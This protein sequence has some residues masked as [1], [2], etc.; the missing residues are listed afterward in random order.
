MKKTILTVLLVLFP[1]FSQA[2]DILDPSYY[3]KEET[4][5]GYIKAI[6][7]DVKDGLD[8]AKEVRS[9]LK[10]QSERGLE[11]HYEIRV[12]QLEQGVIKKRINLLEKQGEDTRRLLSLLSKGVEKSLRFVNGAYGFFGI[13]VGI[14]GTVGGG[15]TVIYV[16]KHLKT[17]GRKNE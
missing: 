7:D 17:K 3:D 5:K 11:N 13:L 12:V 6:R 2:Q 15:V 1:L 10:R 9:D 4:L 8:Y 16:K 14:M